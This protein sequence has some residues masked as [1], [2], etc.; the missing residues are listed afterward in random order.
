LEATTL[1]M[2]RELVGDVTRFDG[3]AFH[4][5]FAVTK[6]VVIH[7][8]RSHHGDDD[9]VAADDAAPSLDSMSDFQI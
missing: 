1:D 2:K 6:Q 5:D 4:D 7:H 3:I 9:L 8:V